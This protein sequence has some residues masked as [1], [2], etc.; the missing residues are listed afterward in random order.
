MDDEWFVFAN[1]LTA[2]RSHIVPSLSL[3]AVQLIRGEYSYLY[4]S[5]ILMCS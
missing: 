5:A 1:S 4:A 2:V 3:S